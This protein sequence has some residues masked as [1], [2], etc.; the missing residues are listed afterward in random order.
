MSRDKHMLFLINIF[1]ALLIGFVQTLLSDIFKKIVSAAKQY[2]YYFFKFFVL[3][4]E[5]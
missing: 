2:A 1:Y 4:V 5:I 3:I